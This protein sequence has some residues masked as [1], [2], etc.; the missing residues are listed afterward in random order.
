MEFQCVK[1]AWE[2]SESRYSP[3][4]YS[5]ECGPFKIRIVD[6]LAL[7]VL[8]DPWSSNVVNS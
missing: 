6:P 1:S 8:V 7:S 5:D 2:M 3:F 4:S